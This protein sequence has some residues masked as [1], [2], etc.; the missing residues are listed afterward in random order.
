M[1]PAGDNVLNR[2]DVGEELV[3]KFQVQRAIL[4]VTMMKEM[5]TM[6]IKNVEKEFSIFLIYNNNHYPSSLPETKLV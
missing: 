1:C 3:Y 2:F 4:K 6:L 5:M